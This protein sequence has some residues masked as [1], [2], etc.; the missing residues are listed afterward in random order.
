MTLYPEAE[1]LSDMLR[2]TG[3][4]VVFAESCT[5]GM[6]SGLLAGVPGISEYLCGSMVTYRAECKMDWLSVP[7][8]MI[9]QHT[10]VSSP[11]TRYMARSVLER[12]P[13][14]TIS[15]AVTGHLGPNAPTDLDGAVFVAVARR[16]AEQIEIVI[17]DQCRLPPIDRGQRQIEAA[18][19]VLS[20]LTEALVNPVS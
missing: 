17:E 16:K 1:R 3:V 7:A 8:D 10:T 13:I 6:V 4:R 12:T 15:A 19:R 11:V 2:R 18:R 9:Q 5:A 20:T 14:A